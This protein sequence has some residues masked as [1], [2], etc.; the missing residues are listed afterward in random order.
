MLIKSR[1]RYYEAATGLTGNGDC[2]EFEKRGRGTEALGETSP[3][4]R[5]REVKV[6]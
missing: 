6:P 4:H 2:G 3:R 1:V 5:G